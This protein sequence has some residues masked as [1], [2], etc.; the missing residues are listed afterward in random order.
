[1]IATSSGGFRN[2]FVDFIG[3][4]ALLRGGGTS[5]PGREGSLADPE[6]V[7]A[8]AAS[9]KRLIRPWDSWKGEAQRVAIG[10]FWG[11]ALGARVVPPFFV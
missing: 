3:G 6:P 8:G 5:Q 1:M 2:P 9:P 4:D 11:A 7:A 10:R